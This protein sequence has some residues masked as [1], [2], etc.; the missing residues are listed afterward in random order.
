MFT[1][2]CLRLPGVTTWIY[3]A[4]PPR[5]NFIETISP[6]EGAL[7]AGPHS[8]YLASL[9]E[10]GTLI[11]A[12]PSFDCPMNDGIAVIEAPDREAALAIMNADPAIASGTMTGELRQIRLAYLRGSAN[13]QADGSADGQA[14]GQA[15]GSDD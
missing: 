9:F 10:A 8:Q 5:E 6:E 2:E 1:R 12:G 3:F 11:M 15:D 14:D 4:H 13:G 7:M